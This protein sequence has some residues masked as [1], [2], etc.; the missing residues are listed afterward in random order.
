MLL[1]KL[2]MGLQPWLLHSALAFIYFYAWM[3][4][5]HFGYKAHTAFWQPR[6]SPP[7]PPPASPFRDIFYFQPNVK[8]NGC[9]LRLPRSPAPQHLPC[10]SVEVPDPSV[11]EGG[12][13]HCFHSRESRG[14]WP[15][16]SRVCFAVFPLKDGKDLFLKSFNHSF[17][18]PST[19]PTSTSMLPAAHSP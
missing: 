7:P 16:M 3:Q 14:K 12:T 13:I 17:W 9:P 8:C 15:L 18:Y 5:E 6:L 11:L 2:S 1:T 4:R 10:L 19:G